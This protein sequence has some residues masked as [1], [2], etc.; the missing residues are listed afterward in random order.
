MRKSSQSLNMGYDLMIAIV[1]AAGFGHRML[2]LTKEIPKCMISFINKPLI[3]YQIDTFLSL[4]ITDIFIITG[5]RR[6]KIN[7]HQIKTIHNPNYQSTN[8]VYSLFLAQKQLK[9]CI[10]KQDVIVSYGD[11][12]FQKNTLEKL[13]FNT[14]GD[15]QICIDRNFLPYWCERFDDPLSDLETLKLDSSDQIIEI[16]NKPSSLDEI[17]GQY[18]GL[19]KISKSSIKRV[20]E[21]YD[22]LKSNATNT[23]QELNQMY[24]TTFLNT[25]IGYKMQLMPVVISNGWLEFDTPH[26]YHT[27]VEWHKKGYLNQYYDPAC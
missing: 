4:G 6:N 16:G 10:N 23:I 2:P 19:F 9:K 17:Q 25:L 21:I 27:Y 26:D 24:M 12:L 8:M 18:I 22:K 20:I 14:H 15:I 13:I 1:L 11:I 3:Q 7:A 5:Y